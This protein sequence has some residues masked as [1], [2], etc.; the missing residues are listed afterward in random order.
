MTR[1][2][3]KFIRQRE[4]TYSYDEE[5]TMIL[6]SRKVIPAIIECRECDH[7]VELYIDGVECSKCGQHYNLFGQR[8]IVTRRHWSE[9]D[10]E[11]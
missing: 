3:P 8:L 6:S 2:G 9:T 5:G 4:V 1:F 11:D 10:K 7:P